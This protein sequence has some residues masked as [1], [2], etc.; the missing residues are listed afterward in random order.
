MAAI[1]PTIAEFIRIQGSNVNT[2]KLITEVI[3]KCIDF[4]FAFFSG[5][6]LFLLI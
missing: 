1:A 2:G 6:D 3:N 5:E 4:A